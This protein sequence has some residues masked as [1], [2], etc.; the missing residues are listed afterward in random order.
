MGGTISMLCSSKFSEEEL[1]S[2]YLKTMELSKIEVSVAYLE[3]L[4]C[5]FDG[6]LDLIKYKQF[7]SKAV[8]NGVYEEVQID[9]FENLLK[10]SGRNSPVKRIGAIIC[11]LARENQISKIKH[12]YQHILKYYGE[13]DNSIKEFINDIIDL[14]TDNCFHSF[15][16]K[17]NEEV[18]K[19]LM[20]VWKK[21][22]K[23]N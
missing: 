16:L 17:I 1:V 19:K 18:S 5:I 3:F 8:G 15:N 4:E 12:L 7:V 6:R 9:Y 10:T 22:R 20:N 21:S 11:F 13:N 23:Q 14:N 2:K